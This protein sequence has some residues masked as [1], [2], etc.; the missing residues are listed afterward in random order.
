MKKT[1]T[2]NLVKEVIDEV[3]EK[4]G[5][6][7]EK[8]SPKK[9]VEGAADTEAAFD[10]GVDTGGGFDTGTEEAGG[11]ASEPEVPGTEEEFEA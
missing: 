8:I 3:K 6:L 1:D 2:D 5:K 10:T 4:E 11:I 7:K 9:S